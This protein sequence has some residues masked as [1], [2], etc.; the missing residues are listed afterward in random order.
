MSV[1]P[2][3]LVEPPRA[4]LAMGWEQ[5]VEIRLTRLE[6]ST[7]R[8]EEK[9]DNHF[10]AL[11]GF[12][13]RPPFME[14][15]GRW[16]VDFLTLLVTRLTDPAVIKYTATIAVVALV[17]VAGASFSGWGVTIGAAAVAP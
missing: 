7:E 11:L 13:S 2:A 1:Q 9:L 5:R 6:S 17:L 14:R 10:Q 12:V 4:T 15:C 8:V 16:G 3:P